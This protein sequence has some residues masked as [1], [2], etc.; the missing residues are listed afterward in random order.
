VLDVLERGFPL[1]YG[2]WAFEVR[3]KL[4]SDDDLFGYLAPRS[5]GV[6]PLAGEEVVTIRRGDWEG[7]KAIFTPKP[8]P[9]AKVI[10][11]GFYPD[12][13]ALVPFLIE[14][15]GGEDSVALMSTRMPG[16]AAF[17]HRDTYPGK[18]RSHK[19]KEELY[20]VTYFDEQGPSGHHNGDF[21]GLLLEALLSG[22]R[23][24]EPGGIDALVV[25]PPLDREPPSDMVEFAG[26]FI[27]EECAVPGVSQQSCHDRAHFD[28]K[29]WTRRAFDK[30][31]E[32]R[33]ERRRAAREGVK[34][35]PEVYVGLA[36]QSP[37]GTRTV[38]NENNGRFAV[39][40]EGARTAELFSEKDV[41]FEMR[42]DAA[43][44]ASR[45]K[46]A[47][48]RAAE[49]SQ[50]ELEEDT[51]GFYDTMTPLQAH[52]ARQAL[53]VQQGFSGKYMTRKRFI[54]E[55]VAEGWT[56]EGVHFTGP[57]G[58]YYTQ[59]DITKTAIDYAKHLTRGEGVEKNPPAK[60]LEAA[61]KT[62]QLYDGSLR[63]TTIRDQQRLYARL[64][65]QVAA[66][67]KKR[68]M[69]L[70]DVLDQ[71]VSEARSRGAI[72]PMPGKDI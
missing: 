14:I 70:S 27:E 28:W 38:I 51:Q 15:L 7:A 72:P 19:G 22:Y 65:N 41:L 20:R 47:E 29:A 2:F 59:K 4:K 45:H 34:K 43:N 55:K 30:A 9:A 32:S 53:W 69:S 36:W 62:A 58:R 8:I 71:I 63:T 52:K 44:L 31:T 66:I 56:V 40:L 6:V 12:V 23:I 48:S 42:R 3:G 26:E 64:Q 17:I 39:Q 10:K 57:D 1:D 54:E 37:Q 49:S 13:H 68:G 33:L 61:V 25:N 46:V 18:M 35:N 24:L 5:V 11:Y 16:H 60:D 50:Q 21:E 67:A